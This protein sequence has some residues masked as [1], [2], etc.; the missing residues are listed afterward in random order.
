MTE[1]SFQAQLFP[2]QQIVKCIKARFSLQQ[3]LL[4]HRIHTFLIISAL[5][6]LKRFSSLAFSL[7]IFFSLFLLSSLFQSS[8]PASERKWGFLNVPDSDADTV[9]VLWVCV[10]LSADACL[11][12]SGGFDSSVPPSYVHSN[13]SSWK[14]TLPKHRF[15]LTDKYQQYDERV[16]WNGRL[17]KR[18]GFRGDPA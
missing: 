14:I 17:W 15:C 4:I 7:S 1:F 9:S 18:S 13:T 16:Q 12:C 2:S 10:C 3:S 11:S 5:C 6:F 8:T